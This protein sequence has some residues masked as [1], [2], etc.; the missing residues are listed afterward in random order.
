MWPHITVDTR[1]VASVQQAVQA[2][3]RAMDHVVEAA[4][5]IRT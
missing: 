3:A 4:L 1:N 5:T 2:V